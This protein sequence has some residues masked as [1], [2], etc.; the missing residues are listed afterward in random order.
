VAAAGN[1][2]RLLD[3][4]STHRYYP[5]SLALPNIVS[6]GASDRSDTLAWFSNFGPASV[7]LVAPGEEILS[8]TMG[9]G[10]GLM[11]GTSMATP[12]VTGAAVL[13]KS[14]APAMS[15]QEIASALIGTVDR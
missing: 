13:L 14:A 12:H 11:S 7:D 1:Q 3:A 15:H 5:A 10:Y 4:P 9:G 2:T 8:T 6:V